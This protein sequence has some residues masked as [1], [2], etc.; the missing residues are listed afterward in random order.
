M[1][2]RV[3]AAQARRG[4]LRLP[5]FLHRELDG[6]WDL[7]LGVGA[8]GSM[9]FNLGSWMSGIESGLHFFNLPRIGRVRVLPFPSHRL[10]VTAH[11]SGRVS[12]THQKLSRI[13]VNF[14]VPLLFSEI[15]T[16]PS[17][18]RSS[19]TRHSQWPR[20]REY[21]PSYC[22]L[23]ISR[24]ATAKCRTAAL[25]CSGKSGEEGKLCVSD[26]EPGRFT[27]R[28]AADRMRQLSRNAGKFE[29]LSANVCVTGVVPPVASS[30]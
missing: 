6:C 4:Q 23:R 13:A 29:F 15:S 12:G 27:E 14:Q 1:G 24:S 9:L 30:R 5:W 2:S 21:M 7:G 22:C 28:A 16:P 11:K 17:S 19:A 20:F 8:W 3:Q 25:Q 10:H 18:S 26:N